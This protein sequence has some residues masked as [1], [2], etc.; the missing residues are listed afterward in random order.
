MIEAYVCLKRIVVIR[1]IKARIAWSV[2]D[3]KIYVEN[4]RRF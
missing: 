2:A 4:W 3:V 1:E